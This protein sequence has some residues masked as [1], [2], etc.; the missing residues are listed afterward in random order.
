LEILVINDGS[1]EADSL[2]ALDRWRSHPQV[3]VVDI[4]NHG[5]AHVRNIGAKQARGVYLSFLDADDTVLP[6]YYTNAIRVFSQYQ[7][8]FFAGSWIEYFGDAGGIWPAFPP[9]RPYLLAHNPINSSALV[10]K[11]VAFLDAGLND[12][13]LEFGLEDY[14][15]VVHMV[16][17]GFNGVVLP[18]P[19]HRYRVRRRSMMRRMNQNKLLLAHSYITEKHRDFYRPYTAEVIQ[20]LNSNG[21]GY[22]FENPTLELHVSSTPE[23]RI[24]INRLKRIVRRHPAL[25]KLLLIIRKKTEWLWQTHPHPA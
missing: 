7:N 15:S 6:D 23:R 13:R 20:L 11:T 14:E 12:G 8:V 3:T 16:R 9:E 25:K 17:R 4:P 24:W 22:F 21:P 10:Y 5:L 1:T 19:L 18:E 2:E